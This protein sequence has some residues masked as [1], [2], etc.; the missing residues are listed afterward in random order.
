MTAVTV[1]LIAFAMSTGQFVDRGLQQAIPGA[2]PVQFINLVLIL[3]GGILLIA[4]VCRLG[5][6]IQFVPKVVIS[7]FMSGIAILIWLDQTKKLFG[8]GGQE[9]LDGSLVVNIAIALAALAIS[10]RVALGIERG[11]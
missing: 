10:F 11:R 2:D 6:F 5:R 1:L 8:I 9:R 4:A 7:G 3:C